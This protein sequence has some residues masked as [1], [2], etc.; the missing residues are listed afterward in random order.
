MLI[1]PNYT[2][3]LH[4]KSVATSTLFGRVNVLAT[5]QTAVNEIGVFIPNNVRAT[6][7]NL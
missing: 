1:E 7:S 2:P 5:S 6:A 4:P 3:N